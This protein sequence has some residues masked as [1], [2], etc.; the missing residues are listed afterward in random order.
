ML[1][2]LSFIKIWNKLPI[3]VF[4]CHLINNNHFTLALFVETPAT[5]PNETPA[6]ITDDDKQNETED[7]ND[8]KKPGEENRTFPRF[9]LIS[10][11]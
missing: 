4:S 6:D 3:L 2:I 1:K 5:Q 7:D 11:F 9:C 10:R 8:E